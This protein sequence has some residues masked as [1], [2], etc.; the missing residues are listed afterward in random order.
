MDN[1]KELLDTIYEDIEHLRRFGTWKN[2]IPKWGEDICKELKIPFNAM[3]VQA[4]GLLM[5]AHDWKTL[6]T[7]LEENSKVR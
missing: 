1:N 2:G 7:Q 4:E 5:I 6:T 3:I